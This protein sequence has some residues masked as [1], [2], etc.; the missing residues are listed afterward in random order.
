MMTSGGSAR[1]RS[2]VKMISQFSG[3]MAKAR[4]SASSRP[5]A[6][7]ATMMHS[8]RTTVRPKPSMIFGRYSAMT[9]ALKKLSVNLSQA[10][11]AKPS[12]ARSGR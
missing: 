2:T 3:R 11:M 8:A 9:R 1:N 4:T 5:S 6:S 7:P 10:V 12:A